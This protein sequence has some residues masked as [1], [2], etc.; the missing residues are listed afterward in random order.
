VKEFKGKVLVVTGAGSGIGAAIALEGAR[1]GMKIVIND[2]DPAGVERTG[3]AIKGLGCEVVSHVADVSLADSVKELFELT[4]DRCGQADILVNNAGVAVSGPIW[5]IPVQDI[6]WITEVNLLGHAYGMHYFIPQMIKQG[7]ECAVINVASAA[8]ITISPHSVM[9]HTTKAGDLSLAE[10]VY[11]SL[12]IR[13]INNIQVHALC[14][15]FIKTSI[16]ESDKRRPDRYSDRSD[17]YYRANEFEAGGIRAARGVASGIDID[18]VGMTVFTALEDNKFYIFTHPEV[19]MG[20][21][22]RCANMAGGNNPV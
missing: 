4:I 9:Y 16:H 14:P 1:R 5:E 11:L 17:P 20:S 19:T 15:A 21:M 2:I 8:G 18:S 7:S 10:G 22:M 13:G 12:K 6:N 3:T